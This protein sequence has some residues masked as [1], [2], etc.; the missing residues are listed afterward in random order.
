MKAWQK[1]ISWTCITVKLREI[2]SFSSWKMRKSS[3]E[4]PYLKRIS[5]FTPTLFVRI[6]PFL[7]IKSRFKKPNDI[8]SILASSTFQSALHTWRRFS[9]KSEEIELWNS[10]KRIQKLLSVLQRSF[11]NPLSR[12][13]VE[14]GHSKKPA[15][16]RYFTDIH[17]FLM[18]QLTVIRNSNLSPKIRKRLICLI[19][20]MWVFWPMSRSW[21]EE[22]SNISLSGLSA[23][24]NQKAWRWFRPYFLIT[25][26]TEERKEKH[27]QSLD[28]W[29]LPYFTF[30]ASVTNISI[31]NPEALSSST[32]FK[33]IYTS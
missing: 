15:L 33:L 4:W 16:H 25:N 18:Q 3:A 17:I 30:F 1:W 2:M 19:F 10:N 31:S 7:S 13:L 28:I 29:H 12:K 11:F 22:K 5:F 26:F 23:D 24:K 21:R 9:R 32:F 6:D 20:E 14:I 8:S 27:L